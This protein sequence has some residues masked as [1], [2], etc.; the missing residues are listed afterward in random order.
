MGHRI[1]LRFKRDIPLRRFTMRQGETWECYSTHGTG[2]AYLEALKAKEE[3]FLF[4][5]ASCP[6]SAVEQID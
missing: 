4:D 5:G 1:K 6:L 2:K 3:F